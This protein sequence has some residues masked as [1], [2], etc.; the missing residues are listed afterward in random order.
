MT[1]LNYTHSINDIEN[2]LSMN[3]ANYII[4]INYICENVYACKARV[5]V[6]MS[7]RFLQLSVLHGVLFWIN[8]PFAIIIFSL[9]NNE[10][11]KYGV[12]NKRR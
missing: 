2:S 6:Y 5:C 12:M 3:I 1:K 4:D 8:F 10:H 11:V 7:T 9:I